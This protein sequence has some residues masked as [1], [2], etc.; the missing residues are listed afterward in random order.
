MA[1]VSTT[2]PRAAAPALLTA[3]LGSFL[4]AG[5]AAA[6]GVDAAPHA[7]DPDCA[8][9]VLALPDEL[10]GLPRLDTT[11]QATAAWGTAQAPVTLRCG[12]E[13]PGPTTQ[14]CVTAESATGPSVDWLVVAGDDTD[15]AAGG[16]ATAGGDDGGD[17]D[18]ADDGADDET[19]DETGTDEPT[20]WTFTTYGRD[21]AVEVHVPAAVAAEQSTSFLDELGAA[22]SRVEADRSCV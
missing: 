5:C 14:Q 9:V 22:V 12:V 1:G 17:D 18:G 6:A 4:L 8:R 21:P 16:D 15:A 11:S 10:G 3:A 20:D 7:T 13:P 19:D 2:R